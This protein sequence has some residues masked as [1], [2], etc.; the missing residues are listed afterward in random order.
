MKLSEA[1]ATYVGHK[2][3]LGMKFITEGFVLRAF[4]AALRAGHYAGAGRR[5]GPRVSGAVL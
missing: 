2:R 3:S 1:I 4:C 5:T